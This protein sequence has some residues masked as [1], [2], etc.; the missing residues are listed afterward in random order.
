M[1]NNLKHRAFNMLLNDG[2]KK[3]E[4]PETLVLN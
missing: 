1:N 3:V 4:K 2:F